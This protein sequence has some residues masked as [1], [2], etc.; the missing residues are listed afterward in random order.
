[1]LVAWRA[2]ER[3]LAG[4]ASVNRSAALSQNNWLVVA[5]V[6]ENELKGPWTEGAA[7]LIVLPVPYLLTSVPQGD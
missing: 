2:Y 6:V 5:G 3:H 4:C 7:G 1:M